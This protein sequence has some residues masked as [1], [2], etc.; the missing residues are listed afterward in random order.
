MLVVTE[1]AG[2]RVTA[3]LPEDVSL[4]T[5]PGLRAVGDRIIDEGCRHLTLDASHTQD[6]DSTGITAL[7]TWYRRL[8]DLGGT[9]AVIEVSDHHHRLLTR[10]G[11]HTALAV[12]PR[13]GPAGPSRPAN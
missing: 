13:T 2:D 11:L 9:L 4:F 8:E 7:V 10:L 5:V 6:L 1:R 12:S 3:A